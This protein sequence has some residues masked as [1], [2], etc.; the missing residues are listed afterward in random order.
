MTK[1]YKALIFDADHTLLDYG[2]DERAALKRV[3]L[4][5]GYQPTEEDVMFC[6]ALSEE[7]WTEVG[8]Y[9]VLSPRI[10]REYHRLYRSHVA[11]LFERAF[12]RLGSSRLTP[13][14]AGEVFLQELQAPSTYFPEAVSVLKELRK[15]YPIYLATNGLSSIQR[16]RISRT[17]D[18]Y[19]GVFI[20]EEVGAIKPTRAFF[21]AIL[22]TL[23]LAETD[24]LMIGDSLLSD[25][26]GAY[27]SGIDG[28][29]FNPFRKE[30][31]E[32][33]PASYE[34]SALSALLKF[35]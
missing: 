17:A 5:C 31:K 27:A 30:N 11:L 7:A 22:A 23:N 24:V 26:N 29:W 1:K 18:L 13:A 10:Q 8:L 9:D 16:G 33:I 12:E 28:C 3:L 34:I 14:E 32:N 4:A 20:S 15:S 2:A 19:D 35:L 25:M 21:A 6:H